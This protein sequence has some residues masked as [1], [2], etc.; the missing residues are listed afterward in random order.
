[1][2]IVFSFGYGVWLFDDP[3]TSMALTGMT[4]IV[5]AGLAATML[6]RKAVAAAPVD[7]SQA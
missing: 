3:V 4:F 5:A 6:R 7:S 1:M 2:G